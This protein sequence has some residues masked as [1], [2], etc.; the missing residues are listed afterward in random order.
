MFEKMARFHS[1]MNRHTKHCSLVAVKWISFSHHINCFLGDTLNRSGSFVKPLVSLCTHVKAP[2][3][4]WY[5]GIIDYVRV[6]DI[7]DS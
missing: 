1:D 4:Y 5:K 6:A 3:Y 7:I 2:T